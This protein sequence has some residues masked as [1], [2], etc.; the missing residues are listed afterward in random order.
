MQQSRCI[1]HFFPT[2]ESLRIVLITAFQSEVQ[3]EHKE[4][5]ILDSKSNL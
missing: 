1:H 2:Y 5:V 4:L 3:G